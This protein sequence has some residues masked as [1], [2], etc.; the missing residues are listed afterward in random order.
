MIN[1][2]IISASHKII[3]VFLKNFIIKKAIKNNLLNFSEIQ[4]KHFSQTKYNKIDNKPIGG[5]H[6]PILKIENL[7][8]AIRSLSNSNLLTRKIILDPCG[9]LF[10]QSDALRLSCYEH[11][12]FICGRYEGFDSRIY[13]YIDESISIGPF[14]LS[15]GEFAAITILDCITRLIP[16]TLSN[17]NSILHESFQMNKFIEHD[18][19]TLPQT[20]ENFHVPEILFSGNH[21]KIKE[22]KSKNSLCK[23]TIYKI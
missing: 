23:S 22:F 8:S 10:T 2:S 14:T 4:L 15:N 18:Q 21:K 17:Y 3:H 1:V 11:L 7:V 9:S 13:H 19:Y 6:G 20:F 5:K 16:N 12:I